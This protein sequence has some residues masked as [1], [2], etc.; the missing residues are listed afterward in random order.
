MNVCYECKKKISE[1]DRIT[2]KCRCGNMF[3]KKHR[4]THNCEYDYSELYKQTHN[5]VK[6]QGEKLQS[7]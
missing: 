5:L 6:L 7:F 2:N 1:L 3:C 4:L